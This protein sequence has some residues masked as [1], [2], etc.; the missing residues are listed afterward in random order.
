MKLISRNRI[1][2]LLLFIKKHVFTRTFTSHRQFQIRAVW[3]L[4]LRWIQQKVGR[5]AV[6]YQPYRK[7]ACHA[8]ICPCFV[9]ETIQVFATQIFEYTFIGYRL[10]KYLLKKLIKKAMHIPT[11]ANK[12][13]IG[14]MGCMKPYLMPP[15]QY[16]PVKCRCR[17]STRRLHRLSESGSYKGFLGWEQVNVITCVLRVIQGKKLPFRE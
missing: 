16:S 5:Y 6:C 17:A 3:I 1:C 12:W 13:Y 4:R 15:D 9:P 2:Q 14:F 11:N 8:E 7:G 10:S